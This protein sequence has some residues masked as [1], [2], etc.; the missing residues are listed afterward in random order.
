MLKVNEGTVI[1]GIFS[2]DKYIDLVKEAE[3]STLIIHIDIKDFEDKCI[4]V[5]TTLAENGKVYAEDYVIARSS[6]ES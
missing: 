5:V 3:F 1:E 4:E 6:Y 2:D